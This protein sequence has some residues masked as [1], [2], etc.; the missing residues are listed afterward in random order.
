M[1]TYNPDR[2][3]IVR[4]TVDSNPPLYKVFGCWYGGFALG[5]SWRMNSGIERAYSDKNDWLNFEGYTGSVYVCPAHAYGLHL[6]GH[7]ILADL[8]E[9]AAEVGHSIEIMPEDTDWETLDYGNH[10]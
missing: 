2:W 3:V 5:D 9:R 7:G 6:Y 8:Q 4:I 10:A 1:N